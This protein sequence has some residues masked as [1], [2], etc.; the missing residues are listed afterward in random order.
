MRITQLV[1]PIVYANVEKIILNA[2]DFIKG[3]EIH[4][5]AYKLNLPYS[6]TTPISFNV[7]SSSKY[8]DIIYAEIK[9]VESNFEVRVCWPASSPLDFNLAVCQNV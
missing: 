9:D 5:D 4:S 2:N 6:K 7:T 8:S 3:T 1:I